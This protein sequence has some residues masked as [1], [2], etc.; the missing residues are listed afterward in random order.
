[1]GDDYS[2]Y[3]K[4]TWPYFT[5]PEDLRQQET[6]PEFYSAL[7]HVAFERGVASERKALNEFANN[8]RVAD[9]VFV[10]RVAEANGHLESALEHFRSLISVLN[11]RADPRIMWFR[12][13][14]KRDKYLEK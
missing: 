3:T 7:V 1:M 9:D 8:E 6:S 10:S 13:T 12:F 14:N 11:N 2:P 5:R 4:E